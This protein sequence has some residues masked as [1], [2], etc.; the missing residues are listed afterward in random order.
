MSGDWEQQLS[1]SYLS[2]SQRILMAGPCAVESQAQ[3]EET[4]AFLREQ[5]IKIMR[6]GAY[7]PRTS[8][9]SFQG[10]GATGLE[11]LAVAAQRYQLQTVSEVMDV[12]D[13]PYFQDTIDILQI[14]TRNMQNF[15]LLRKVGQTGKPVMLKRGFMATV[16]EF[17]LAAEYIK[18]E[19]NANIILCERGIRTFETATRNTLDL[20]CIALVQ[21]QTSYPTIVD[22]SNSLGRKDIVLPLARAALACGVTGLMLEIHPNPALALCDGRQS[23]T[24]D[25]CSNLLK[26]IKPLIA[27]LDM[28]H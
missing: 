1:D 17:L 5:G 26:A 7:K 27:H 25:E 13:L 18:R 24:F 23:L 3:V 6:G 9:D 4:A 16:E 20:S 11:W 8:P 12:A 14:G 15:A 22:L 2:G 10:V 19:G 21:Q 28:A